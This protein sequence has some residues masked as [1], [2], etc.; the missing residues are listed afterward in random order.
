MPKK[1]SFKEDILCIAKEVLVVKPARFVRKMRQGISAVYATRFFSQ[2]TMDKINNM[3]AEL[4]PKSGAVAAVIVADNEQAIR[5]KDDIVLC[6]FRSMVREMDR[7]DLSDF[8]AYVTGSQL[9]P[10]DDIRVCFFH[11]P[12]GLSRLPRVHLCGTLVELS[13][14]YDSRDEMKQDWFSLIKNKSAYQT[15]MV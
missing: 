3:Y 6:M 13:S 15:S 4:R 14:S 10:Q 2:L 12:A 7:E 9:M 5:P 1:T 11:A 8:L